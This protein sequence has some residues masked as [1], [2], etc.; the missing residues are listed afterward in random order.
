MNSAT[1][2]VIVVHGLW[3]HPII[4]YPLGRYLTRCGFQVKSF[5]YPSTRRAIEDNINKLQAFSQLIESDTIH[6]VGHSLG[7]LVIRRLFH[8]F[9]MQRPGRIVTLGTPHQGSQVAKKLADFTLGRW[10]LGH[11]IQA[12]L[13]GDTPTWQASR[14]LGNLVGYQSF[15]FGQLITPLP[16]PNDGTVSVVE[17]QLANATDTI[18][19]AVTHT[20][21]LFSVPVAKQVET[22]LRMGHFC[23]SA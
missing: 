17:C 7:G 19:L 9:P 16:K 11:S 13:L 6:F 15:G 12:G 8:D 20:N 2:T 23:H 18:A 21:M 10:L 1:G 4:M 3:M 5:Y 14:Q 22:F